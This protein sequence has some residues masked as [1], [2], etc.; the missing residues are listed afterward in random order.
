MELLIDA[1]FVTRTPNPRHVAR[2]YVFSA[3]PHGGG[4]LP[5]LTRLATT[6]PGR[7]ALIVEIRR[8]SSGTPEQPTQ[9][10]HRSRG[11]TSRPLRFP[12]ARPAVDDE[13]RQLRTASTDAFT[14]SPKTNPQ[15]GAR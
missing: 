11:A 10:G 5:A 12:Q 7:L 9:R 15:G 13:R 2:M 6:R 3:A 4:W 8:R 1:G 14:Q